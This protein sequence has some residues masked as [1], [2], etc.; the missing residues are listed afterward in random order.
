MIHVTFERETHHIPRAPVSVFMVCKEVSHE[1]DRHTN[2]DF[3]QEH[4]VCN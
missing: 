1:R 4:I 3:T 2:T